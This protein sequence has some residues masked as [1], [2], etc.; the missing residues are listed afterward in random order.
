MITFMF[1]PP[2]IMMS[3]TGCGAY[4]CIFSVRM[5]NSGKAKLLSCTFSSDRM[6]ALRRRM[7]DGASSN[8]MNSGSLRLTP[9]SHAHGFAAFFAA[10]LRSFRYYAS[11]PLPSSTSFTHF[12]SRNFWSSSSTHLRTCDRGHECSDR[13]SSWFFH[14]FFTSRSVV[15]VWIV[16]LRSTDSRAGAQ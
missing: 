13:A 14:R 12:I 16:S 4:T 7:I 8:R 1:S 6:F 10:S 3:P 5:M 2:S 11:L 9:H 15:A